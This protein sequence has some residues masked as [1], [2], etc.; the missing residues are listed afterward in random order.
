MVS[1]FQNLASIKGANRFEK[2]V[3]VKSGYARSTK[4]ES[5]LHTK[6]AA[7]VDASMNKLVAKVRATVSGEV[8]ASLKNSVAIQNTAER[9]VRQRITLDLTSPVFVYQVQYSS[10]MADGSTLASWG[11]GWIVSPKPIA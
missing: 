4:V 1:I 11:T 9:W 8:L 10:V 3:Y 7:Q 6:V 2:E 5:A